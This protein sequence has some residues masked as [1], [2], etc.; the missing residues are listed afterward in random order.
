MHRP[1]GRAGGWRG[2]W[3]AC[4]HADVRFGAWIRSWWARFGGLF[5]VTFLFS[6]LCFGMEVVG[7]GLSIDE[8]LHTVRT[9]AH[10]AWLWQD[11]WGMFLLNRYLI[12]AP[13]L[14][15]VS[16]LIGL[17]S[18]SASAV[19]LVCLWGGEQAAR[20]GWL[21]AMCVVGSPV[22][23]FVVHF[24]TSVYGFFLGLLIGVG[25]LCLFVRGGW[26]RVV[27]GLVLLTFAVSVYQAIGFA[28]LCA[29]LM[30]L[31]NRVLLNEDQTTTVSRLVRMCVAYGLWFGSGLALHKLSAALVRRAYASEGSYVLVDGVYSRDL[32]NLHG[33]EVFKEQFREL[34]IGDSWYIGHASGVLAAICVW[35]ILSRLVTSRRGILWGG[36]GLGVLAVSFASPFVLVLITAKPWPVRTYLALPVLFGGLVYAGLNAR[37]GIMRLAVFLVTVVT[38]WGWMLSNNRLMYADQVR[39][40]LDSALAVRLQDRLA[41]AGYRDGVP[42]RLVVVGAPD[43]G[44]NGVRIKEET[45]GG[46]IFEWDQ[47]NSWRVAALLQTLGSRSL[48]A[49][50]TRE[51]SRTALDLAEAMPA[52]PAEGSVVIRDGLAVVK[53]GRPAHHL[54]KRAE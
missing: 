25:G 21:P 20:R 4:E 30:Y 35:V 44:R 10:E 14:P 19:L 6:L 3:S 9:G 49:T 43:L 16:T 37:L 26:W 13:T 40:R 31:L 52:W 24:S 38:L 48:Q 7:T 42:T 41:L 27:L 39:W 50:G 8:A 12:P 36:I 23:A 17:L 34:V 5:A 33:I 11:R 28:L 1:D 53:F 15:Y 54:I 18:V 32:L 22:L 29:Y 45:I 51:D 2:A 47:G 46:S